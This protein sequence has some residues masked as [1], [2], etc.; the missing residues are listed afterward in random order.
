MGN[1]GP[2]NCGSCNFNRANKKGFWGKIYD[3]MTEPAYCM[4]RGVDIPSPLWIYCANHPYHNPQHIEVPVGPIYECEIVAPP[5]RDGKLHGDAY[6]RAV[7]IDSPDTEEIR[8]KLIQLLEELPEKPV[9][10]FPTDTK[11]D[12]QIIRQLGVF[13]ESRATAGL[14]RVLTFNPDAFSGGQNSRDRRFTIGY[15]LIALALILGDD[16]HEDIE[17]FLFYGLKKMSF[18]SSLFSEIKEQEKNAV[19]RYFA[20]RALAH[21]SP[22]RVLPLLDRAANDP[23]ENVRTCAREVSLQV[24]NQNSSKL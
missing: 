12:Y 10:E 3:I 4:I 21:C 9:E 15:A 2:D 11:F 6:Q 20:V 23:H 13:R 19:I 8:R 5:V 1:G 17:K 18:P 24:R 16:A 7:W 14:R 22:E